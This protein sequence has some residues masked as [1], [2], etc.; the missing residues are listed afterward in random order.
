MFVGLSPGFV[1]YLVLLG[2]GA[3]LAIVWVLC[4]GIRQL[5]RVLTPP[6]PLFTEEQ[7]Q[8]YTELKRRYAAMEEI[9][10]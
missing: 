8:Y 7:R 6:K 4:W 2:L 5:I 9:S 3:M 10:R 1:I